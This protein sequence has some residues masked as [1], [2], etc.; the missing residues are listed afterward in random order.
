M[1]PDRVRTLIETREGQ[2]AFQEYFVARRCEPL[3]TGFVFDGV[4][5]ARPADAFSQSLAAGDLQAIVICPSNPFVSVAPILALSGVRASLAKS[6]VPLVAV[7]PIVGG[8][9]VKGPAAKMLRELGHDVSPLSVAILYKDILDGMVID[10][11]DIQ[12]VP[13]IEAE[14]IAVEVTDTIML[15]D[16]GRRSLAECTLAFAQGLSHG[17]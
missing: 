3:A 2:L 8:D 7:S 11:M 15:S 17:E 10:R 14:G 5:T 16:A 1:S 13:A 4:E 9:A 6:E 12:W